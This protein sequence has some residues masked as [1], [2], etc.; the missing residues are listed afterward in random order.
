MV[1]W[2]Q[3]TWLEGACELIQRWREASQRRWHK[4]R[5]NNKKES[6]LWKSEGRVCEERNKKRI[7][8]GGGSMVYLGNGKV[9]MDG[10]GTCRARGSWHQGGAGGPTGMFDLAGQGGVWLVF[11]VRAEHDLPEVASRGRPGA[12]LLW[13][14]LRKQCPGCPCRYQFYVLCSQ[15]F[16]W[17]ESLKLTREIKEIFKIY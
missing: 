5:R 17:T 1:L 7:R 4:L 2:G 14:K 13:A 8:G 15:W 16:K 11:S 6:V 9:F 3:V 12:V 10:R